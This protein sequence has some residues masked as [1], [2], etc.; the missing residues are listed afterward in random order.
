MST[1][2]RQHII[3]TYLNLS[4]GMALMA[5]LFP[6]VLWLGGLSE[7]VSL[8]SSMSIYYYQGNGA[9]RDIFV[10]I[11]VAIGAFLYLYKGYNNMENIAL[12]MAGLF[13]IGVAIFP[14]EYNCVTDCSK[15]TVH[16]SCAVL[17]FCVLPM[18]PSF[19]P[20]IRYR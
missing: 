6:M 12:N 18:S 17:F 20:P 16:K 4:F 10:G 13:A 9:L 8:Q 19:A 1:D 7:G 5:A 14:T 2:L 3:G 11:L 15:V